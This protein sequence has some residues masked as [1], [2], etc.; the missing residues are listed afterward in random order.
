MITS[1]QT[2]SVSR[3]DHPALLL[4][5]SGRVRVD[6]ASGLFTTAMWANVWEAMS[7]RRRRTS[8]LSAGLEEGESRMSERATLMLARFCR[9]SQY[10]ASEAHRRV[11]AYLNG[12]VLENEG[13]GQHNL[14]VRP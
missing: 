12:A 2:R 7:S 9:G 8:G 4:M 10:E 13:P 3:P 11:R 5:P 14:L 1:S 6:M